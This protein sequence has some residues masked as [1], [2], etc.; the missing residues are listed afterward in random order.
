[1]RLVKSRAAFDPECTTTRVQRVTVT[2][3]DSTGATE[4][5]ATYDITVTLGGIGYDGE[6]TTYDLV[7]PPGESFATDDIIVGE[8][9][10]GEC[11]L[12]DSTAVSRLVGGIESISNP[13][14]V[15]C[16]AVT[17]PEGTIFNEFYYGQGLLTQGAHCGTDYTINASFFSSATII[18]GLLNQTIY[19]TNT[20]S[21]AFNGN[22]LWYPVRVDTTPTTTLNGGYWVIQIN[23]N[24]AVGNLVF[25]DSSCDENTP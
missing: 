16:E 12:R 11:T 17:P 9:T 10:S 3:Y 7:I 23:S 5:D 14:I 20:G 19:T 21:A 1:V 15:E 24:G 22:N 18:S 6:P 2:L 4:V 13:S 25:I 8:Q